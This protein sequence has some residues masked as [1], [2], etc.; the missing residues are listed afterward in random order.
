MYRD[1]NN[2][3]LP[4]TNTII[5]C[6]GRSLKT[7]Q[8]PVHEG[9]SL[10]TVQNDCIRAKVVHFHTLCSAYLAMTLLLDIHFVSYLDNGVL[11]IPK[12]RFLS[13]FFFFFAF[14]C[15]SK[16]LLIKREPELILSWCKPLTFCGLKILHVIG[17]N[18]IN[19]PQ[20]IF[21]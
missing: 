15:F 13:F 16:P 18:R 12:R 10:K 1:I 6:T 17:Q 4:Y 11:T 9:R 14:L 5:T 3:H 8:R 19:I 7:L 2:S 21:F 20:I